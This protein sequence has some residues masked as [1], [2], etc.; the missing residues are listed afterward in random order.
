M[1]A[2]GLKLWLAVDKGR[3]ICWPKIS[4][5]SGIGAGAESGTVRLA[6][7]R[8]QVGITANR[9]KLGLFR[10]RLVTV[11]AGPHV[12]LLFVVNIFRQQV[13]RAFHRLFRN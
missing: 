9:A 8:W 7:G 10:I 2:K 11:I 5:A 12:L 1:W 13:V 6:E 4:R 3:V